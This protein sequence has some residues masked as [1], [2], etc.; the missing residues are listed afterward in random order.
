MNLPSIWFRRLHRSL[1]ATISVGLLLAIVSGVALSWQATSCHVQEWVAQDDGS[2]L[3]VAEVMLDLE[4]SFSA[5]DQME[6]NTCGQWTVTGRLLNGDYGSWGLRLSS[7]ELGQAPTTANWVKWMTSLHRSL[8]LGT[9]G[10]MLVGLTAVLFLLLLGTGAWLTWKVHGLGGRG[11]GIWH[12]DMGLLLLLPC[13]ILAFTGVAMSADRFGFWPKSS[14]VHMQT[15]LV[16]Q[17][18]HHAS[19]F[20]V[21][22]NMSLASLQDMKWPFALEEGEWFEVSLKDG[23]QLVV[24]ALSGEVISNRTP[25]FSQRALD[26]LGEV[27]TGEAHWFWSVL[28]FLSSAFTLILGWTGFKIWN[29]RRATQ[30]KHVE[31]QGTSAEVKIVVA[32]QGGSTWATAEHWAKVFEGNGIRVSLSAME[33]FRPN[34]ECRRVIFMAATYGQGEA[35]EHL[36]AWK[37]LLSTWEFHPEAKGMVVAFGDKKYLRFAQFG[38]DLADR[39]ERMQG[40]H[41]VLHKVNCRSES[42]LLHG[43]IGTLKQLMLSDLALTMKVGRQDGRKKFQLVDRIRSGRMVWLRFRP[44]V[45]FDEN[46]QS[47]DLMALCPPGGSYDRM[48]SLSIFKD[49]SAG[50]CVR[51]KRGGECST[52]LDSL[53]VGHQFEARIQMN[54]KFHISQT[55]Q[56]GATTFICN[57][58]GI[59]PFLGMIESLQDDA[60]ATLVWGVKKRDHARFA[61]GILD[62]AMMRGA[63]IRLELITSQEATSNCKYVQDVFCL[64]KDLALTSL[65]TTSR[66]MICGSHAMARDVESTFQKNHNEAF[67]ATRLEGR[68]QSDCY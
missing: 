3:N 24:D 17:R 48:Y 52:W 65:S 25:S 37:D 42:D 10:R 60:R 8:F 38:H 45:P 11:T 49:Q 16:G 53:H 43:W 31:R 61:E 1:A 40:L 26:W 30:P 5:L 15:D 4:T 44:V 68:W 27:H 22:E 62:Q 46:V 51:L 34:A 66:V 35:P 13:A 57:G 54:P 28:W 20:E 6:V 12:V 47:G 59:G 14:P 7:H 9:L 56:G 32:S 2:K 19:Q 29:S 55:T 21:F 39:L 36:W 67:Q 63:L 33:S 41:T 64:D 58:S 23:T 50:M 18:P